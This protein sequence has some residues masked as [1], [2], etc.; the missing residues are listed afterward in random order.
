MNH[1]ILPIFRE[2]QSI[3]SFFLPVLPPLSLQGFSVSLT[4]FILLSFILLSKNFQFSFPFLLKKHP[5]GIDLVLGGVQVI[6][7]GNGTVIHS[8]FL[9]CPYIAL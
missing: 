4:W 9:L 5:G 3:G 7:C 2:L 8:S 1:K 6:C